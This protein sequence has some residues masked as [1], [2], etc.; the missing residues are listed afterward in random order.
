[1]NEFTSR[2]LFGF[3]LCVLA[4]YIG[5][6]TKK[7]FNY[8]FVTPIVVATFICI[9]VLALFDI[10]L[11]NFKNGAD[12][13]TLFLAPATASLALSVYR[14]LHII[15]NNLLPITIGCISGSATALGSV[16]LLCGMLNLPEDIS[17]SLIPKS[18]TSA[19]A[20]ELS[21]N[22]GGIVPVTIAAVAVTGIFG[23]I[24]SPFLLK[25]FRIKN[26]V[27][28]GLAMGA[29][30]HA[31]GTAKAIEMG[32]TEGSLSGIAVGLCGLITVVFTIFLH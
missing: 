28:S 31:L 21:Q 10:P 13:I 27:A 1:M 17:A 30:S 18:V 22:L 24:I 9:A 29:S 14:Q 7:R 20:T 3:T 6:K 12:A 16:R 15:R 11:R 32:E 2:P 19:I 5:V 8:S 23:T 4:Y 25:W 26:P